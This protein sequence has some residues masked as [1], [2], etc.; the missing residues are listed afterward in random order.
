MSREFSPVSE[1]ERLREILDY[2]FE[3]NGD[4]FGLDQICLLAKTLFDVPI[5]VV[6]F[7]GEDR[8]TFL[9]QRGVESDGAARQ[10]VFCNETIKSDDLLV[11]PDASAD[12]K[13]ASNRF[14]TGPEHVR[15][16]AG[17]PLSVREGVRLGALCI[18]D[19]K[20]R[21][22][23]YEQGELLKMLANMAINEI[24]RRR[25]ALDLKRQKTLWTQA[26]ELTSVGC[27]AYNIA[28]GTF[29][30]CNQS[31]E[32]LGIGTDIHATDDALKTFLETRFESP[33][34]QMVSDLISSGQ[35]F[36]Q[37]MA[38]TTARDEQRWIRLTGQPETR[39][40][41]VHRYTGAVQDI[42]VARREGEA[43]RELAYTDP[44]TGLPNRACADRMLE[45]ALTLDRSAGK[46]TGLIL[47]D[48]D[49]F[50]ELNR[51]YG[52]QAGDDLLRLVGDRLTEAFQNHG[53]VC[54][55]GGDEF[56]VIL[57]RLDRKKDLADIA[58]QTSEVL[59]SPATHD[60]KSISISAS[61]GVAFADRGDIDAVLLN[62]NACLALDQAKTSGRD[63]VVV[64][65]SHMHEEYVHKREMIKIVRSGLSKHE[66]QPYY[67][68][69]LDLQTLEVCG[70]EALMRWSRPDGKVLSPGAFA[71]AFDD[72]WLAVQMGDYLIEQTLKH[73]RNWIRDRVDFKKVAINVFPAQLYLQGYADSLLER[74][75]HLRVPPGK[76]TVEITEDVYLGWGTDAVEQNIHRLHEAGVGIALDDFGTGFA[77]LTHLRQLPIRFVKLDKS[78]VQDKC[79]QAI[80]DGILQMAA[81]MQLRVIAEGIE[82]PGQLL[83]LQDKNCYAA[84]GYLFSPAMSAEHVPACVQYY[85]NRAPLGLRFDGPVESS[86]R[87]AAS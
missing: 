3:G 15:F 2:Q 63:K 80:V 1:D 37:E 8:Q 16:Y 49:H 54:R 70:F 17:V 51:T 79:G 41:Y 68:P 27:W 82:H 31:R 7:L 9:A 74:M 81:D 78:F 36:D 6:T 26:A 40:G 73:M 44:L 60:G 14:V 87:L 43:I 69:V 39:D 5:A 42:T 71:T 30:A 72:Q 83:S 76:I 21:S 66:F 84:Q 67:Q 19:Y 33:I 50:K 13:Y 24:H 53:I 65:S 85:K 18:V 22:W 35:A 62:S 25:S 61:L 57:P 29:E 32:I 46:G 28:A 10:D 45:E 75:R 34:G 58:R 4:R 47:L 59:K 64:F 11:I 55:R 52:S 48:L 20:A 38:L 77:S 86:S 56:V 12:P 23:S